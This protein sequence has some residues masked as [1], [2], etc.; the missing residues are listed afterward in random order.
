[1]INEIRDY[2]FE[3]Y[4]KR[5]ESHKEKNYYLIK[6]L[7]RKYLLLLTNKLIQNIPDPCNAKQHYQSFIR[8][9]QKISKTI[10]NNCLSTKNF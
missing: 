3:N 1:M 10:K 8:I 9:K 7:I 5:I 4:Y 6:R 2:I